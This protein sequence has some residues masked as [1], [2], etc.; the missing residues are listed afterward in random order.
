MI[1]GRVDDVGRDGD[2]AGVLAGVRPVVGGHLLRDF[3]GHRDDFGRKATGAIAQYLVRRRG[4]DQGRH[5]IDRTAV[6]AVLA[7]GGDDIIAQQT[8]AGRVDDVGDRDCIGLLVVEGECRLQ[9]DCRKCREHG[10]EEQ[11]LVEQSS[12]EDDSFLRLMP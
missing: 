4:G 5:G 2:S 7:D 12:H 10:S 6:V 1:P 9:P 11:G 8:R 3:E